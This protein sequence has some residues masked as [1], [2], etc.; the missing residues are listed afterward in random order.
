MNEPDYTIFKKRIKDYML[1]AIR[2][3]K[4]NSSWISP[5]ALYEDALLKFIDAMMDPSHNPFIKDLEAFQKKVSY[6]GMFNS[7]SQT[8][9]K[10]T[11][12][13]IPDFYQGTEIWDFSLVDPDN[14]RPVHFDIRK[15]MLEALK[16]KMATNGLDLRGFARELV[17]GWS[18]GSIKLY[19][20][21]KSLNYRKENHR[22]FLDGAYIPL[23]SD[24]ERKD[25]VCAFARRGLG[26]V[27]LII[28]PRFV[29]RLI[30]SMDELPLGSEVWRNSWI[31]LPDEAPGSNFQNIFTGETV[32]AVEREGKVVLALD[33][34]FANFPVAMLEKL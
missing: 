17:Q 10:I 2:E 13:G 15:E 27:V 3:A 20:I 16:N 5:N 29:T 11:S 31:L 9:L 30:K 28:V 6:L 21:F 26:K 19:V 1:K 32:S 8:L 23:V 34:V 7:L 18:D 4:V 33:Q 12:P 22:L 25:H 24:G 14:R